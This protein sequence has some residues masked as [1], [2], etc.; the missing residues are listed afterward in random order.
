MKKIITSLIS[1][2]GILAI[3]CGFTACNNDDEHTHKYNIEDKSAKFI[4]SEANCTSGTVIYYSC[5]C[6]EKGEDTFEL[7][8]IKHKE[9]KT[10]TDNGELYHKTTTVCSTCSQTISETLELHD[11]SS[12]NC[13]YCDRR[14][15]SSEFVPGLYES[16][17]GTLLYS[18]DQL[19]SEGII[20]VNESSIV[21]AD[22]DK[23]RG[24]LIV[25]N[26]ITKIGE[27]AFQMCDGITRVYIPDTVLDIEAYAFAECYAMKNLILPNTLRTIE[28]H[29][30]YDCDGL[31]DVI[32]PSSVKTISGFA[33]ANCKNIKS[34]QI[35]SSTETIA[36]NA[37]S[38]SPNL[39]SIVIPESVKEIDAFVFSGCYGLTQIEYEGT[40]EKWNAIYKDTYWGGYPNEYS[41]IC[42]DGTI[43]KE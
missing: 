12:R 1:I 43:T 36:R 32:V 14:K 23:L 24:D 34:M 20:S 16:E 42:K 41:V 17:K 4:K 15:K 35:G 10:Y 39:T 37:F 26:A 8:N 11:Y 27:M 28:S 5:A 33:F 7:S 19:L 38:G 40:V 31:T 21:G 25:S 30:F 9:T 2:I 29:A 13:K 3:I 22:S 6:G 18:W